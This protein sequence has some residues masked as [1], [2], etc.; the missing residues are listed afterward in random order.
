MQQQEQATQATPETKPLWEA[1]ELQKADVTS[2]TLA[3]V[4]NTADGP[5]LS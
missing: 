5:G 1:P 4:L 3:G 2:T